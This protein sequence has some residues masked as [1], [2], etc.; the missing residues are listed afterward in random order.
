[1]DSP[2]ASADHLPSAPNMQ[3]DV[4]FVIAKRISSLVEKLTP[5]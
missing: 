1:M 4:T 2:T 5:F 3:D